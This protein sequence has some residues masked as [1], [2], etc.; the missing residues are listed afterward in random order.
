MI[1]ISEQTLDAFADKAIERAFN[2]VADALEAKGADPETAELCA[3][4][5]IELGLKY[6]ITDTSSLVGIGE[7]LGR[8]DAEF[9]TARSVAAALVN[10]RVLPERRVER[11][12]NSRA[13]M[14]RIISNVPAGVDCRL[15]TNSKSAS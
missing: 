7:L 10:K 6:E 4:R 11:I 1:T 5:A 8:Y 3:D 15:R 13:L 12:L 9:Y 14:N 2:D